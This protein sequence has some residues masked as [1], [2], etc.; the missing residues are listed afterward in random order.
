MNEL[1]MVEKVLRENETRR[2]LDLSVSVP[3]PMKRRFVTEYERFAADYSREHGRDLFSFVP[4]VCSK[5]VEVDN[6]LRDVTAM[7]SVDQLP[8]FQ[9][10]MAFGD[11]I[12]T[13]YFERFVKTGCFE[14]VVS[15]DSSRFT[16]GEEF[17]DRYHAFNVI[18][19]APEV[20]LVNRRLLGDLPVPRRFADL[21]DPIYEGTLGV[22]GD[23]GKKDESGETIRSISTRLLFTVY[24]FFGEEGLAALERNTK[25][26]FSGP[27]AARLAG[28]RDPEAVPIYLTSSLFAMGAQKK[29]SVDVI[30][31]QDG[32]PVQPLVLMVKKDFSQDNRS[33]L[34]WICSERMGRVFADNHMISTCPHVDDRLPD[35]AT[36]K[37][38]GWDF[39]YDTDIRALQA[40]LSERF[41]GDGQS[42][43]C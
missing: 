33:L 37:W 20:I 17:H 1:S 26:I 15:R 34:D 8:D 18:A 6:T 29:G 5:H 22:P 41:G 39:L 31:P 25:T 12:F 32:A 36:V 28:S 38:M 3:C 14:E 21:L 30:W 23:H 10:G 11:F 27:G 24:R 40:R 7:K 16:S 2:H 43:E 9:I 13:E 19:L 35:D 4:S 42:N